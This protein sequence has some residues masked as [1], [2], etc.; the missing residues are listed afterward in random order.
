MGLYVDNR[1]DGEDSPWK[2]LCILYNRRDAAVRVPLEEGEWEALADG[3]DSF[4]WKNPEKHPGK[5]SGE[6][7]V[8][9]VSI[10]VLGKR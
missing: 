2:T 8:M 6:A 10:L 3:E 9:P 4:L 7:E 1:R 5:L